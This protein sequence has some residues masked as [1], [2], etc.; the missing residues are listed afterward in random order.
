MAISL[1][2]EWP[3]LRP[4]PKEPVLIPAGPAE[5]YPLLKSDLATVTSV[6]GPAYGE[7]DVGAQRAQNSFRRQ[8]VA[9]ICATALTTAFG[10]VQAG[11]SH[12]LWPGIVVAVLGVLSA[13]VA[14]QG[15]ERAAQRDYLEQRTRAERLR[16]AAFAYLAELPPFDGDDRKDKLAKTV[17]DICEGHEP[18]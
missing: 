9:L 3:R 15:G 10:A 11:F 16:S 17:A 14:G 13:A 4:R 5:N 8:Q 12:Q 6:I 2:Q 1:F 18:A 7:Y